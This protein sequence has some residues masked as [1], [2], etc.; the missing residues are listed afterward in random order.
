M[1]SIALSQEAVNLL[2]F[3]KQL[4]FAGAGITIM[5][6]VS[7][8]DYR[9]IRIMSPYLYAVGIAVLL[10]VLELGKTVRGTTGWFAIGQFSLQPVEFV[11]IILIIFL[12]RYFA[13]VSVK[14]NPLK[15]MFF[16][17]LGTFGFVVLVLLQPDFGSALLL[18][19]LWAAML[20]IAGF[21]GKYM[22]AAGMILAVIFA[23]GW[24][25]F[26]ADYQKERVM[27][28]LNPEER[29]LDEGYNIQQAIIAVGSGQM[30]GRGLGFGSQSQ[31]KFLPEAQTDFIFAVVAEELGFLGV[32][33]IVGFFAVFLFRL[34]LNAKRSDNDFAAYF[35]LGAMALIFIEM[36][37]NIG[38]NIGLMPVVGIALP[39][40][41]Y[42]GS[43]M[44]STMILLGLCQGIIARSKISH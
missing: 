36:F 44:I 6:A 40:L 28:F 7:L 17:G 1:Y 8:F 5:F 12:A 41:S 11:K 23:T 24:L 16:S 39:F 34:L 29:S 30:A 25:F 2:N 18:F 27:T 31:L 26:F 3:Q 32:C 4:F 20:A 10:L 21:K 9:N 14:L 19:F 22:L 15:H 38:M 42:G 35:L 33:L 37:I 13:S 43:M